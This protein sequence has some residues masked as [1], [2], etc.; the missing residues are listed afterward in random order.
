MP[1]QCVSPQGYSGFVYHYLKQ[2]ERKW[3]KNEKESSA[4]MYQSR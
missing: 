2:Y 3:D 4:S 1:N